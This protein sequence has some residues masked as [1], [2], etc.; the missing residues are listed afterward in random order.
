MLEEKGRLCNGLFKDGMPSASPSAVPPEGNPCDFYLI[1]WLEP[2]W[3][4]SVT[5]THNTRHLHLVF[6]RSLM[7][8]CPMS[9]SQHSLSPF[10]VDTF[11]H[12]LSLTQMPGV[13]P[14]SP[15]SYVLCGHLFLLVSSITLSAARSLVALKNKRRVKNVDLSPTSMS[16]LPLAGCVCEQPWEVVL[17]NLWQV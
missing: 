8:V 3:E 10:L 1:D 7:S 6:H 15:P 5:F 11:L 13:L 17:G 16:P 12:G 4:Y 14:Q 2:S 9:F